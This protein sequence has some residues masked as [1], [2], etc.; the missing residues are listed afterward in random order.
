MKVGRG[1]GFAFAA[2]AISG[3]AVFVNGY[4]VRAVPD[5]TVYTTAKNLVAATVLGPTVP[6]LP[7]QR[8][9]LG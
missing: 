1:I 8:L 4:G 6:E 9:D 2:A 5:A 7:R 3:V